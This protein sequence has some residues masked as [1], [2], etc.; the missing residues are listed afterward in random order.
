[1]FHTRSEGLRHSF[2]S[3]SVSHLTDSQLRPAMMVAVMFLFLVG[4]A[5]V[6]SFGFAV[7]S[8][9]RRSA[10]MMSN[11]LDGMT[12]EGNLSPLSNNLFVKV[13]D[14]PALTKSGFILPDKAKERPTEG[15]VVS[16]GPGAV[17][18]DTG[19]RLDMSAPVGANVMYSKYDGCKM[20][21]ND[22]NHQMIKDDDVL[23]IYSGPEATVETVQ[24][25]KDRVLIKLPPKQDASQS[26]IIIKP[27]SKEEP[28]PT[29]G[30]VVKVGP[31]KQASTGVVMPPQVEPGDHVRFRQ[32][33]GTQLKLGGEDYL[34]THMY[35]ILAKW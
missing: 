29:Y 13:K 4:S 15:T 20:K 14:V 11:K 10:M 30:T 28:N 25:V 9:M 21:Y 7:P 23:L 3:C 17:H 32:Y 16:A 1:M 6:A 24:C 2:W 5:T 12:I 27:T 31:G 26:G 33:G 35:D 8:M 22:E 18:P 19:V 34:V